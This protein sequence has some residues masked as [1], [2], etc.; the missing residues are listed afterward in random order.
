MITRTQLAPLTKT[1]GFGNRALTVTI[2]ET[3]N[4]ARGADA[5]AH[6]TLQSLGNVRSASW[7]WSVDD[8]EAVQS[9]PHSVKCWH[10]G[11]TAGNGTSVAIEICV[12]SDGDYTRA[13]ANAAELAARILAQHGRGVDDLRQHSAWSGKDCP[14]YL[15]SGAKGPTWSS[16][17]A[18]VAEHLSPSAPVPIPPPAPI[19][20]PVP[21]DLEDDDMKDLI[22]ACYHQISLYDPADSELDAV[23]V[24]TAGLSRGQIPQW[25]WSAPA[26]SPT[27]AQLYRNYLG[28]EATDAELATWANGVNSNRTVHDGIRNSPEANA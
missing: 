3:A 16:F 26:A 15:R 22:T 27:V 5:G 13:V 28:R 11:T 19:P 10:S 6:A 21:V 14:R 8:T 20:V 4:T 18:Q 1:S 23:Q 9:F 12:N 7:H 17:V 24:A 2:H 25:F